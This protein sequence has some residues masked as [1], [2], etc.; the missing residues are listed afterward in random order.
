MFHRSLISQEQQDKNFATQQVILIVVSVVNMFFS[1]LTVFLIYDIKMK[2]T[3]YTKIII[4]LAS[5]QFLYDASFLF[6]VPNQS[7]SDRFN[8]TLAAAGL[9]IGI[10]FGLIGTIVSNILTSIVCYVVYSKT[11]PSD[12]SFIYFASFAAVCF[13]FLVATFNAFFFVQKGEGSEQWIHT[14][15]VYNTFRLISVIYNFIGIYNSKWG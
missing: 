10:F 7:T 5:V 4:L 6:F 9:W 13:S 3:I 12:N 11:A 14:F 1:L 15:D 8:N 2:K